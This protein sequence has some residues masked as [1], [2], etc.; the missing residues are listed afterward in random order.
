MR[1]IKREIVSAL[2]ISKDNKLLMGKKDPKKG[3]VYPDC[4]HIPGGGINDGENLIEAL[5]R[6]VIEEVGIDISDYDIVLI[7]NTGRGK[8]KKTLKDNNEKVICEMIFNVYEVKIND[9]I[10]ADIKV[11]LDDDLVEY[12]WF[13]KEEIQSVKLTPPSVILFSKL[14]MIKKY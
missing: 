8:S 7:D 2:L 13:T 9:K 5:K 4:W 14:G 10:A 11:R 12:K 3:G 1:K 6:E